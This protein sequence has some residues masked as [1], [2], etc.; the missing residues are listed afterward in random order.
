MS[1]W[2]TASFLTVY[3]GSVVVNA[4]S[5]NDHDTWGKALTELHFVA[6]FLQ[7]SDIGV[8]PS[9]IRNHCTCRNALRDEKYH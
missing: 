9:P 3:A 5:E 4:A 2:T 8:L 6:V 7:L 1:V